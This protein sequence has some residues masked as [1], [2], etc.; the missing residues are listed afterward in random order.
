[1]RI[2]SG[3]HRGRRFTPPDNIPTRPTTDIAKE[4]LFN[5]LN[6]NIEFE[7]TKYLDL[8]AGTGNISYEMASRGC[9]DITTVDRFPTCVKYIENMVGKLG[10]EGMRVIQADVFDFI[11]NAKE[12]YDLIFAGPPYGLENLD[13]IPNI[14]FDANLVAEDGMFV[15]EHNPNHNFEHDERMR[16][17]R[18]YGQTIFSFFLPPKS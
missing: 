6:N 17:M 7:G 11:A 8:F 3:R 1:M 4:G 14:I 12:Q 5:I 18:N 2:I 9:T 16:H 15:L 10:I 13:D